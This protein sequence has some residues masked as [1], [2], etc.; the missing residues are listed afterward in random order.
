MITI[1]VDAHKRVHVAVAVDEAG[2]KLGEHKI[3]NNAKSWRELY[4]WAQEA[5]SARQW[6]IEG[7]GSYGRGL[8]QHLVC[9]GETVYEVNPRLTAAGRRRS[10]RSDKNDGLDAKSV[11][12]AV[13]REGSGLPQ[14]MADD[15]TAVLDLLA[16]ERESLVADA[17]ALCNRIHK[18]LLQLDPEYEAK[19]PRLRSKGG[20]KRLLRYAARDESALQQARAAMVRKLARRMALALK[21]AEELERQIEELAQA[22]YEPLTELSGVSLLTAG[23]LAGILGPG[24]RFAREEQLAAY[25]GVAPLETSS[26]GAVRHRLNR[27][28]NRRLNAILYRIAL[29]QARRSPD[30]RGYLERRI[31]EGR[32][33]REAIRALK[34]YI[35]RAIWHLWQKCLT[36]RE[37]PQTSKMAQSLT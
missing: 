12:M 20:V 1:G 10:R 13:L 17:T 3:A 23:A 25:G 28:G 9:C 27:S 4:E 29:T 15:E 2:R 22:S 18:V 30:T 19:L 16:T 6:G 32:T 35:V 5:G 31:S 36:L 11:A 26:A 34:R 33:R 24:K 7:S 37:S 8:A 14:V 21:Q